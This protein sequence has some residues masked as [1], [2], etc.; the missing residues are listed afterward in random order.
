MGWLAF[1]ALSF[2]LSFFF[3]NSSGGGG[4]FFGAATAYRRRD[5]FS[6]SAATPDWNDADDL[7]VNA[8]ALQDMNG[9]SGD[10]SWSDAD[11]GDLEGPPTRRTSA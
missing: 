3:L 6:F 7:N 1:F 4:C 10:E 5:R 11:D 8:V 2:F 9:G